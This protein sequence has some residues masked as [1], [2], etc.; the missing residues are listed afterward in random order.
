MPPLVYLTG[1]MAS[2]KSTVGPLVADALGYRFVDLD[3]LVEARTGRSVAALFADGGEAAFRAA[4]AQAL[5]ETTRGDGL[6]VAT[7][8][9]T[10]L[11]AANCVAA[12]AAGAVV[13]LR[14]SPEEALSRL[15]VPRGRPLLAGPDGYPLAGDALA[16]RVGALLAARTP[17]YAA[18]GRPVDADAAPE[19]VARRVMDAL[20]ERPGGRVISER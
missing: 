7:G 2:G 16:A 11:D 17:L 14:V 1:F 19:T 20:R 18:A 13:W 4:E 3:W 5:A 6:V 9:G 12:L 10:L 15:G 8:G